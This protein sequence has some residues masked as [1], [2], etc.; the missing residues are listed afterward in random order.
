MPAI[1]PPAG[2]AHHERYARTMMRLT[3]PTPRPGIHGVRTERTRTYRRNHLVLS[4]YNAPLW[5]GSNASRNQLQY[6]S[7]TDVF[8]SFAAEAFALSKW[9]ILHPTTSACQLRSLHRDCNP[10]ERQRRSARLSP[11]LAARRWVVADAECLAACGNE[12]IAGAAKR[13]FISVRQPHRRTRGS[14]GLRGRRCKQ[15]VE[16]SPT[17]ISARHVDCSIRPV[18]VMA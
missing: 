11:R 16:S 1:V 15:H 13:L 7:F 9:Y 17:L 3:W 10:K 5:D 2:P 4:A 8:R 14:K 6:C 12:C 18:S